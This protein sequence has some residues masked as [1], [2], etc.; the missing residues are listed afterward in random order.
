MTDEFENLSHTKWACKYHIVFIP[1]FRR[2]ALHGQLRSHLGEV[3]RRL[4]AQK[5]SRIEAEGLLLASRDFRDHILPPFDE[6]VART[7]P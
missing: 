3:F 4:A 7:K 1:M 5:E 2:K 6:R